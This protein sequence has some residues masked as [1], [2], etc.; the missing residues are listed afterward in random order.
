MPVIPFEQARAASLGNPA[1]QTPDDD[2]YRP[3]SGE[4]FHYGYEDSPVGSLETW[5]VDKF[6]PS[7]SHVPDAGYD[8]LSTLEG[9]RYAP[10]AHSF[11]DVTNAAEAE[12]VKRRIDRE[13]Y[14]REQMAS[15]S[16]FSAPG[17]AGLA[18]SIA[19]DPTVLIPGGEAVEGARLGR[20]ALASAGRTAVAGTVASSI[21]EAALQATQET[22]TGEQSEFN[23]GAATLLSGLF[24]AG[25]SLV[26]NLRGRVA[27]PR[28]AA[29]Q[30][31]DTFAFGSLG[32]AQAG[33]E[34]TLGQEG[35]KSAFGLEKVLTPTSPLLRAAASPS[36]TTR[37]TMQQLAE[38]ALL[39]VKNAEGIAN[40]IPVTR[41]VEL[42]R[43]GLADA[44]TGLDN[45]FVNYRLG[46]AP[47]IGDAARIGAED[48]LGQTSGK[49]TRRQFA[50]E[51]GNAM[52][53]GDA[54]D[55]A[56]VA[57]AAKLFRATVFDPLKQA[58]IENGLLP[59]GVESRVAQTYLTRLFDREKIAARRKTWF[60]RDGNPQEGFEDRIVGWLKGRQQSLSQDVEVADSTTRAT[61]AL[62]D[63]A[64]E[65]GDEAKFGKAQ[66]AHEQAIKY[67]EELDRIAGLDENEMKDIATEVTDTIL[68]HQRTGLN[69]GVTPIQRG[70]L[71]QLTFTIPTDMIKDFLDLNIERV[72]R[73][74]TKT[75][76]AD[77]ELTRRFGRADMEDAFA[78]IRNDYA[79]MR[80]EVTDPKKL[81]KLDRQMEADLRDIAAVRDRIRG[82]YGM[83]AN[84]H[85]I[86]YRV[87]RTTKTINFL[88]SLGGMVISSIPDSMRPVFLHGPLA[89][90]RDAL[91][92]LMTNSRGY[93]LAAGEAKLAGAALE[94]VLDGRAL[95]I[96]DLT[97]DLQRHTRFERG[98]D[99][100]SE[101][102]GL[103]TLM[104][105]WTA[106]WK[107]FSGVVSQTRTLKAAAA[108][109]AGT[110][111][112][113]DIERLAN[114]GIGEEMAGR[115]ADQFER[116]GEDQGTLKWANT[117]AWDDKE[118]VLHYRAALGKEID[119][120]IVTPG[121][122]KPLWMSG[123]LG[124]VLGQF[125]SYNVAAM[126]RVLLAGLQQ[127]DA[128]ALSGFIGMSMAGMLSYYLGAHMLALGHKDKTAADFL[129]DDP[130]QWV[131][132]GADRGGAFGY[133]FTFDRAMDIATRG[134]FSARAAARGETLSRYRAR[135]GAYGLL[136]PTIGD[137]PEYM[138]IIGA[139]AQQ[140]RHPTESEW[141]KED[142]HSLRRMVPLNNVFY[143]RWVFNE[144]EDTLSENAQESRSK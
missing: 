113:K 9:T 105:P 81:T 34:T 141:T 32:A 135:E 128:S 130:K 108:W 1:I 120:A 31:F 122:E 131:L 14:R 77:V 33:P 54:S 85:G 25:G 140:I 62:L 48:A 137:L 114:M 18:G 43:A 2:S 26:R 107:K 110:I 71:K 133:A 144:A 100:A 82:T 106:F 90:T 68:H 19:G 73:V 84:P 117:Q 40:D 4:A 49:M 6:D 61:A 30:A 104:N 102:F 29:D 3:S 44:M 35:L 123:Q 37:R 7:V 125:Q 56:E 75:M 57:R 138:N 10:Y 126:Q 24:G 45:E 69:Y 93:K 17:L 124:S 94:M 87:V 64:R 134:N 60:D 143:W 80:R 88:R 98:L 96:A 86:L 91:L 58:A 76:A 23:I 109:R 136:G 72:S 83:P 21:S 132:E 79:L 42:Y 118:A 95:Q 97:D 116:F 52:L 16:F 53:H 92:P 59:P 67:R 28:E 127:R 50:I 142:I 121:Q 119:K 70:P 65:S 66:S 55:V 103:L 47:Q 20:A 99:F 111:S 5:L 39:R 129:S 27:T 63:S 46:R 41:R 13:L 139:T 74:Y 112:K 36:I 11:I 22:R 38:D 8:A 89:V 51:V 101:K 78:R 115:I 15:V 12:Q